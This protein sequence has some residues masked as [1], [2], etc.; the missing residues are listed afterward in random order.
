MC[1]DPVLLPLLR[2]LEEAAQ[3]IDPAIEGDIRERM[4][5][6]SEELEA[7]KEIAARNVKSEGC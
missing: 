6:R 2:Q 4:K 5:M 1:E 7:F 3:K